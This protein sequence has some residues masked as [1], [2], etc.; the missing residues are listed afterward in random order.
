MILA[1]PRRQHE[2]MLL[3]SDFSLELTMTALRRSSLVSLVAAVVSGPAFAQSTAALD[4]ARLERLL[5]PAVKLA[6]RP[7]IAYDLAD[8]MQRY[9]VPGVSIAVIDGWRIVMAKGYG[10]TQFGGTATVDTSTLFQAGSISKPV[11]ASGVM[12]LIQDG[13]LA[14]DQD[15][16][17]QLRSWRLPDSRFTEQEKVTLRRLLSH[18]AGLTVWGFPGYAHDQPV[19]TVPQVLDGEKPANTAAVRNDTTPGARWLY[20]GGG[21]T[22]AQLVTTDVTGEPFPE[23]MRRLVLTPAGMVHSS[24]ENPPPPERARVAASG[25]ERIDTPVPGRFHTYPEMAAAGLW[26]TASDLARWAIAISQSYLGRPGGFLSQAAAAEMLTTQ[27]KVQPPYGSG[28]WGVGVALAGAGDSLTFS[29]GGRDEGFVAQV[30]MWPRLGRG[31]VIMM[32][33]VNGGLIA[34]IARG[35]RELHGL[36]PDRVVKQIAPSD[37]VSLDAAPGRY[38]IQNNEWVVRRHGDEL[39]VLNPVGI[40]LTLLPQGKDSYVDLESG[41]DWSFERNAAGAVVGLARIQGGRR[42]VAE[43]VAPR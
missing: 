16:N 38:R 9:R 25:H 42:I 19:P 28:E 15:V 31:Y 29:H 3:L 36:P 18:T 6:D 37:P 24:Y 35:F 12:R 40:E 43:R 33:G 26:T 11:F 4:P 20:S 41:V 17:Q 13:R 27:V 22:V 5:R 32:N 14:L 2:D 34:E 30:Y 8:R 10:V 21:F 1:A 23:L 7:D 39:R